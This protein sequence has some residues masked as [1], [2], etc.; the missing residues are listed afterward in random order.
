MCI[1]K[2]GKGVSVRQRGRGK[3]DNGLKL[4][5]QAAAAAAAAAAANLAVGAKMRPSLWAWSDWPVTWPGG[6]NGSDLQVQVE[7]SGTTHSWLG[8]AVQQQV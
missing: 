5:Q 7:G 6:K 2:K 8:L 4:E 3:K 1:A